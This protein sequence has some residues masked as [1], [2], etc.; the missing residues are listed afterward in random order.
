MPQD[1]ISQFD[2]KF[3][4][5]IE[6]SRQVQ[7]IANRDA[8][9]TSKRWEGMQVYVID[10]SANY[11]LRGGI[12]NSNWKL[13]T[14]LS[15]APEDDGYYARRNG[16][17]TPIIPSGIEQS[18]GSWTANLIDVDAAGTYS[19]VDNECYYVKT[20]K[21]V[22]LSIKLFN[23]SYTGTPTGDLIINNLPFPVAQF[24]AFPISLLKGSN[25]SAD[26]IRSAVAIVSKSPSNNIAIGNKDDARGGVTFVAGQLYLM[27][28]YITT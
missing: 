20:G 11:E 7:S 8:I 26:D 27:G 3:N 12:S 10:D 14:G 22:Y 23:I 6:T 1:I 28:S 24:A 4:S 16:I 9:I 17:W 18:E 5:P 25:I 21:I 19:V 15:E 13:V 2:R